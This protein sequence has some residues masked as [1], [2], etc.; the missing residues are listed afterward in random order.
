MGCWQRNFNHNCARDLTSQS[1]PVDL[2]EST[3]DAVA[4]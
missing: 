1:S 2:M 3:L 4:D